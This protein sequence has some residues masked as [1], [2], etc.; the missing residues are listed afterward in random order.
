M[1]IFPKQ[2]TVPRFLF[3]FFYHKTVLRLTVQQKVFKGGHVN[4]VSSHLSRFLAQELQLNKMRA[5]KAN[6]PNS[7]EVNWKSLESGK[8]HIQYQLLDEPNFSLIQVIVFT[9]LIAL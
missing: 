9:M 3:F 7:Q 6:P 5:I 2:Q 1:K 8:N 4:G